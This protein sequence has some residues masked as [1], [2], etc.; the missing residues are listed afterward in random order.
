MSIKESITVVIPDESRGLR[1]DKALVK[2]FPDYS[3]ARL[4][5]DKK[6]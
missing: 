4:K 3:R 6:W 5:M 1:L 2:L